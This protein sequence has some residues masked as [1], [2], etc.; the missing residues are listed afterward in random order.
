M[1]LVDIKIPGYKNKT[2][3]SRLIIPGKISA[4]LLLVLLLLSWMIKFPSLSDYPLINIFIII[5]F[6]TIN[7][8]HV[9]W[10]DCS[11]AQHFLIH[12]RCVYTS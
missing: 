1:S 2:P 3:T 4:N 9:G 10:A 6:N 5:Y 11:E 12:S 7:P 8:V